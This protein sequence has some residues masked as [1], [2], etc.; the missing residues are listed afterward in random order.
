MLNFIARLDG[1][2]LHLGRIA[3]ALERL[4]PPPLGVPVVKKSS[5][6]VVYG[7][8]K[9]WRAKEELSKL[10]RPMGLAVEDEKTLLEELMKEWAEKGMSD[11]H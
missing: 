6:V 3:D 11:L 7:D 1:I 2:E 10:V 8:E 5:G 4:S 9:K